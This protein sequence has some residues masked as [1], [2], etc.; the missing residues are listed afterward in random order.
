M[1]SS[2]WQIIVAERGF[3]YVGRPTRVGD[4]LVIRDSFNVR[5]WGTTG[6]LGEL[7]RLGPR[8]ETVLDDYGTIRLHILLIPGGCIDCDD[9]VWH[10]W[11]ARIHGQAALAGQKKGR[12]R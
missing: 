9:A 3:I 1:E 8:D 12:G 6:G 10:A 11:H 5:R 2:E 4:Q 7:A